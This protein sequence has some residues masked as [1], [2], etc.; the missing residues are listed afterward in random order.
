MMKKQVIS[1][2]LSVVMAVGVMT[3]E[4]VP[5]QSISV[6]D[7]AT[8]K[9]TTTV[10]KESVL[11]NWTTGSVNA[12]KL[13]AY[14]KKVT[15]PSKKASFI[16]KVNRIAVFD[17]DGTLLCETYPTY[18]D[19][20]MFVN[21]ALYD[22]PERVSDEVKQVAREIEGKTGS[23]VEKLYPTEILGGYF[24]KAY[25]GLTTKE[26]YNYTVAFGK[27]NTPYFRKLK[28]GD[29]FYLP[30][31]DVIKYLS[32]NDF[33]IYIVSGTE[34][35][36]VRAIVANSPLKKYVQPDHII[37]TEFEIKVRGHENEPEDSKYQYAVGDDLVYTGN[38]IRKG[39]KA[40]KV[41]TI[42][43]E[44]GKKPVLAFG[45]SSG[46]NSMC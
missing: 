34:R 26:V 20:T 29:A 43:R 23:E 22:H 45:N 46:D 39:V 31:V 3:C 1:F 12:K 4:V 13:K 15:D 9:S 33:S 17:M 38:F 37:G 10:S 30:M 35:T 2:V 14:V 32:D 5:G 24:A 36:A 21:F 44:I 19:T 42:E 7:A 27:K 11:E 28:Y 25:A 16:P 18:Y 41:I 8:S 40:S 6:V